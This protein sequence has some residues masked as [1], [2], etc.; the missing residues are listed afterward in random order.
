VGVLGI[1]ATAAFAAATTMP[2]ADLGPFTTGGGGLPSSGPGVRISGNCPGFLFTDSPTIDFSSGKAVFYGPV[3]NLNTNGGNVEGTATLTFASTTATYVG[4]LHLWF[5]QNINNQGQS[6]FG[7]TLTFQGSG[8][9]GALTI[10]ASG[11][12]TTAANPAGN[13]SGWGHVNVTCG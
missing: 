12:Q 6:Y 9:L 8:T 1:S 10:T 11:G 4:H 13:T 5:G 7:Q 3:S 2:A